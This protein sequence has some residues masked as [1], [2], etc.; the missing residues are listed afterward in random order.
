MSVRHGLPFNRV[1]NLDTGES[2]SVDQFLALPLDV[3]IGYVLSR[4]VAFYDGATLVERKVALA[5]LRVAK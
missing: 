3:K 1:V 2:L 5:S 4:S